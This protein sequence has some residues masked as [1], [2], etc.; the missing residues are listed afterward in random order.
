MKQG[1]QE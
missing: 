1:Y